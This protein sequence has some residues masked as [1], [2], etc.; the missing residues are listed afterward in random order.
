M[1]GLKLVHVSKKIPCCQH[2]KG[3]ILNFKPEMEQTDSFSYDDDVSFIQG[4]RR[5]TYG[6]S[7]VRILKKIK[8]DLLY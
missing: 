7:K 5:V 2:H 4:H 3:E 6:V 8:Q 1:V